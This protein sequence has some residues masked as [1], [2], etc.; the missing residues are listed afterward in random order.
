MAADGRRSGRCYGGLG[1]MLQHENG[2]KLFEHNY[3]L[4]LFHFRG[5][6]KF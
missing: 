1:F 2:H 5:T 4:G 6:F 3:T